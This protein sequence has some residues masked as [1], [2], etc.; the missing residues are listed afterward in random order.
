MKDI[1]YSYYLKEEIKR[2][3]Q[4]ID[5]Y[6]LC[7][8]ESLRKNHIHYLKTENKQ[9]EVINLSIDGLLL[10]LTRV[11]NELPKNTVFAGL[12]VITDHK[13]EVFSTDEEKIFITWIE[14]S[15][16]D[17]NKC[18]SLARCWA[19]NAEFKMKHQPNG[20]DGKKAIELYNKLTKSK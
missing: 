12:D 8:Y 6:D 3:N 20:K 10:L 4:A 17:E 16:E 7:D 11:K 14:Y 18:S 15:V 13:D 19:N 1:F 9:E 5:L 2:R